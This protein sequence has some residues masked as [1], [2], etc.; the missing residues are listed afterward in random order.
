MKQQQPKTYHVYNLLRKGYTRQEIAVIL[1]KKPSA[2]TGI[3]SR[4]L[5][6]YDVMT[7]Y[8]LMYMATKAG[9]FDE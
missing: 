7:Q 9:A 1:N 8:Q 2:V 3:M 6:R 4:A 5:E